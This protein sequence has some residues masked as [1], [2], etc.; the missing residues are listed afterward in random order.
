MVSRGAIIRASSER[1]LVRLEF[2]DLFTLE[3]LE[4]ERGATLCVNSSS[5][6][7]GV[8][9]IAGVD[10][11]VL[12]SSDLDVD[13]G[14]CDAKGTGGVGKSSESPSKV[15]V[16][17]SVGDLTSTAAGDLGE[18]VRGT[19]RRY[20]S[21]SKCSSP[22]KPIGRGLLIL[23]ALCLLVA[24]PTS[25]KVMGEKSESSSE[26]SGKMT[27][28]RWLLLAAQVEIE[29]RL[30]RCDFALLRLSGEFAATTDAEVDA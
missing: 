27:R 9:G 4:M 13:A 17:D 16:T 12:V 5:D 23:R 10:G 24:L 21:S 29:G 30:G 14:E 3:G 28:G 11:E 20:D 22:V 8:R 6:E 7:A 18:G 15:R 2:E 1:V 19:F 25:R 26:R